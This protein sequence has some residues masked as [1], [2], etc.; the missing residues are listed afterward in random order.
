M[1]YIPRLLSRSFRDYN[2]LYP[3]TL[4]IHCHHEH[5]RGISS[6][7]NSINPPS[8]CYSIFFCEQEI[9][10]FVRNDSLSCQ[11]REE[12]AILIKRQSLVRIANSS[13]PYPQEASVIPNEVRDLPIPFQHKTV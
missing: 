13:L 10:H 8:L 11:V 9:P 1:R 3:V 6:P 2:G 12:L 7:L 4:K 5:Q